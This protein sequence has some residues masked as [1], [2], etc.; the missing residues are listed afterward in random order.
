MDFFYDDDLCCQGYGGMKT[1]WGVQMIMSDHFTDRCNVLCVTCDEELGERLHAAE[2]C[3]FDLNELTPQD[4][5]D[6]GL[7][8]F[9][10]EE[11]DLALIVSHPHSQPKKI[12]VGEVRYK[13]EG[14]L[15]LAYDTPTCAGSSGA[16]VMGYSKDPSFSLYSPIHIGY[17]YNKI[18]Q[19]KFNYGCEFYH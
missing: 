2:R 17:R 14:N 6:L 15:R 13:D 19:G 3:G 11:C 5:S 10:D 4:L 18:L 16:P 9:C 12:T 7:L 1:L 8:A